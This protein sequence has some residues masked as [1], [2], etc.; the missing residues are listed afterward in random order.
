M[1][2]KFNGTLKIS[3]KPQA[4]KMMICGVQS[5]WKQLQNITVPEGTRTIRVEGTERL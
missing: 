5:Q 4:N 3:R 1:E 2:G